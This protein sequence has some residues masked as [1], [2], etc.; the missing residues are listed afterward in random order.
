MKSGWLVTEFGN[1]KILETYNTVESSGQPCS[2]EVQYRKMVVEQMAVESYPTGIQRF[3][4]LPANIMAP[5][6][7]KRDPGPVTAEVLCE[8]NQSDS[9]KHSSLRKGTSPPPV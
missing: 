7:R 2:K 8:Q 4:F 3:C 9:E 6:E 1:K 5:M